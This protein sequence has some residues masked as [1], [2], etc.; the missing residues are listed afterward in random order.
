[1]TNKELQKLIKAECK[2]RRKAG[3]LIWMNPRVNCLT[4][5]TR[6]VLKEHPDRVPLFV[7][8]FRQLEHDWY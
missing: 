3:A 5:K 2:R 1:M 7:E 8:T 6:H 4:V